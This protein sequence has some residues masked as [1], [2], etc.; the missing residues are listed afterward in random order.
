MWVR[1]TLPR[2]KP[3]Q[4]MGFSWKF[5]IPLSLINIFVIAIG[6]YVLL[7]QGQSTLANLPILQSGP[8]AMNWGIWFV[9]AAAVFGG[10]FFLMSRLLSEKLEARLARR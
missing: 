2:L 5:L 3:D 4:L 6:K 10:F 8:V 9:I 1:A 7:P